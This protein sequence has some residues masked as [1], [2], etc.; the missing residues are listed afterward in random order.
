MLCSRKY[1]KLD[2]GRQILVPPY[3]TSGQWVVIKPASE[4][5]V[6]RAAG[7]PKEAS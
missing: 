4:E 2:N 1:A 7:P 6:E 3:V 5:F